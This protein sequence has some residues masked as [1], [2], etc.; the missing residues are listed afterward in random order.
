MTL[1]LISGEASES[2]LNDT[3]AFFAGTVAPRRYHVSESLLDRADDFLERA[4][5]GRV[6]RSEVAEAFSTSDFTLGIFANIDTQMMA[7]YDELESVWRSYTDTMTTPDF[8]PTRLLDRWY[9]R[10]GL[11]RVPELTEYPM[12]G[13]GGHAVHW[14]SVAKYGLRDAFSWESWINNTA[15]DE[16]RDAPTKYAE[17][18]RETE[19]INA[20]ANLLNV[21]DET[22]VADGIN[23]DFFNTANGNAPEALPLTAENL[24][25]VLDRVS[26]RTIRGRRVAP[27]SLQLVI[28]KALE[29][30]MQRI[31][32][33]REI[34][35]T[36]DDGTDI[37]DNYLT[38]VEYV[39]EPMLDVINTAD[40]ASTTWF[41]LPK[42][43]SR[44]PASFAAFLRGHETPD[45]RYKADAGQQMGGGAIS[46]LEGSFEIDDIQ[47]RVRHVM[48][49]QHGD[50]TFTYA[51]TGA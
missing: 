50:P 18:A 10:V 42:T 11:K 40:S 14:I 24:D 15:I 9:D 8:R 51:S 45:M 28:P 7:Q 13:G 35:K 22:N 34:R 12:A 38:Q 25:A 29:R 17:A 3:G 4:F 46:P 30:Q 49:R 41:V 23:T 37:Y 21:N 43:G 20:L 33:L 19:T 5:S 36:I 31:Q 39:V 2:A 44:R 6:D 1:E 32:A 26:S 47:T 27:P 16:I 48:G